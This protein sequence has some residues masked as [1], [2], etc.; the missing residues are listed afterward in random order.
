M[1]PEVSYS[2]PTT[3]LPCKHGHLNGKL[4]F[5]SFLLTAAVDVMVSWVFRMTGVSEQYLTADWN[6]PRQNNLRQW[7]YSTHRRPFDCRVAFDTV[8]H[9]ARHKTAL[10]WVGLAD[11]WHDVLTQRWEL[12]VLVF[13][14]SH[15]L[16]LGCRQQLQTWQWGFLYVSSETHYA[17][18]AAC[19]SN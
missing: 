11:N 3:S 18:S 16:A 15:P 13:W 12:C 5:G 9:L 7:I 1:I 2:K 4:L 10:V 14:H 8:D 6:Q 17:P 19:F